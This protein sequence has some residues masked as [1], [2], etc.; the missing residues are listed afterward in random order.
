MNFIDLK[1]ILMSSELQINLAIIGYF[2]VGFLIHK[3]AEAVHYTKT[4]E[5]LPDLISYLLW[6]LWPL[7]LIPA[8]ITA[9]IKGY[10]K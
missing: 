5:A 7:F 3:S 1:N 6:T 9:I 2:F 8:T 10:K 4:R